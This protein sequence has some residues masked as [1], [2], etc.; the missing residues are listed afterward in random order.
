MSKKEDKSEHKPGKK[1][2][3]NSGT[4][5]MTRVIN[6]EFLCSATDIAHYPTE[7]LPAFAFIGRSN[8]GKS[9]LINSLVNRR[10]LAKTSK[11]PGRTQLVNFFKLTIRNDETGD[12]TAHLVDLPGYG[13]AAVGKSIQKNWSNF[14]FQ[15][16][17]EHK[18][19]ALNFLLHDSRRSVTDK[20]QWMVDNLENLIVVLTKTDKVKKRDIQERK[21]EYNQKLYQ[22]SSLKKKGMQDI[23]E[24]IYQNI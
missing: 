7:I 3:S 10:G 22:T 5:G 2:E 4:K 20:E 23:V 8:V 18:Y 21:K 24:L 12:K 6:A 16:F 17:S 13:Y 11:Q 19:Q 14:I 15:Y 1:E 9:S